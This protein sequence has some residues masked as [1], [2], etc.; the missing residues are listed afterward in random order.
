MDNQCVRTL[1]AYWNS[2][3]YFIIQNHGIQAF[4]LSNGLLSTSPVSQD[5]TTPYGLRGAA[6]VISS[7]QDFTNGIAWAVKT[8]QNSTGKPASL[9]AYN[10]NSV[11]QILYNSNQNASRDQ[12]FPGMLF[13]VPTVANGKVYVA[14]KTKLYVFGLLAG[15]SGQPP[16]ASVSLNSGSG[17]SVTASTSGS[18]NGSGTS[19]TVTSRRRYMSCREEIRNWGTSCQSSTTSRKRRP[20]G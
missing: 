16:T 12:M 14:G 7:K 5:T 17:G 6:P 9:Y 20:G 4:S 15:L 13:S 3:V 18:S 8:D 11:S 1:P 2:K 10:A 19:K